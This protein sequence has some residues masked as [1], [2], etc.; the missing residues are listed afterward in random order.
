MRISN[1]LQKFF[2]DHSERSLQKIYS[3]SKMQSEIIEIESEGERVR[4]NY[5]REERVMERAL[6]YAVILKICQTDVT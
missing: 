4:M 1:L 6:L 2:G 5:K 3:K